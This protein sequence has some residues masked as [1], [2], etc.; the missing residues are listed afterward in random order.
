MKELIFNDRLRLARERMKLKPHEA[1][2]AIGCSRPTIVRWE[3]DASSV[4]SEFLLE[5]AKTYK[6]RPE[7]LTMRSDDD[8]YPYDPNEKSVKVYASQIKA[9]D[10]EDGIDPD[11]DVMIPVY[12]IIVS[13]GPG[14]VVPEFIETRYKLAYQI[15]WLRRWGA[16]PEDILVSKVDGHSMEPLLW[17]GDKAVIH[18]GRKNILDGRVYSII[19]GDEARVKR[20]YKLPDHSLRVNSVNPDK[21]QYR[22]EII[23]PEHM[24]EVYIL[25]QVIEKMGS[26]GLD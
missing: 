10:G 22:D 5:V 14:M 3:K 7:W 24:E 4:G 18:R 26:G 11:L 20:L 16:K 25:G 19:Y 23:S 17:H 8:G 15:E 21:D 9:I 6:V 2:K 1:A 12:D 13:G